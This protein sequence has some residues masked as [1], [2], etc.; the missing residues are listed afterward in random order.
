MKELGIND[1]F[2]RIEELIDQ[3]RVEIAALSPLQQAMALQRLC[4]KLYLL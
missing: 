4:I 3:L 1:C 2:V